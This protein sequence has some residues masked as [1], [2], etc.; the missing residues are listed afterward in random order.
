MSEKD[1]RD[2]IIYSIVKFSKIISG[3]LND[4][5]TEYEP[6]CLCHRWLLPDLLW[7]L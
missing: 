2:H 7:T 3:E 5:G 4:S 6:A 1:L